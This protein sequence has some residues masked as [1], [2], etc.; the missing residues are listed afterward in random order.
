MK[1]FELSLEFNEPLVDEYFNNQI[2]DILVSSCEWCR[3]RSSPHYS[4]NP[5]VQQARG[6]GSHLE[7][8]LC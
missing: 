2:E 8:G 1:L 6:F 3:F 5:L 7:L 4:D